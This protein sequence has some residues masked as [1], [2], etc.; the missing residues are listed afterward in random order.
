MNIH[1]CSQKNVVFCSPKFD[2][3]CQ[4]LR[5]CWLCRH[6]VENTTKHYKTLYLCG[7]MGFEV[8]VVRIL[9]CW[10]IML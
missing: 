6:D 7:F 3:V 4:K 5:I 1:L 2:E 8:C 9:Q 10:V